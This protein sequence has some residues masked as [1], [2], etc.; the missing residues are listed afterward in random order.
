MRLLEAAHCS[1][2]LGARRMVSH[3]TGLNAESRERFGRP[4]WELTIDE[5]TALYVDRGIMPAPKA[6]RPQLRIVR[7]G[8]DQ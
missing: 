8:D 6:Q 2:G 4:L 5:V 7:D 3:W 1:R